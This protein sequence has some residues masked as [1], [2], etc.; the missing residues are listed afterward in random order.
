MVVILKVGPQWQKSMLM[1]DKGIG[2]LRDRES[3]RYEEEEDDVVEGVE[4]GSG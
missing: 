3:W 2:S 1:L 4:V